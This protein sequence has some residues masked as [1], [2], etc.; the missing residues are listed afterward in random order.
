MRRETLRE[1]LV[2]MA[3]APLVGSVKTRLHG[4]LGAELA[5]EL[6]RCFLRD[7]FALVASVRAVRPGL[8]SVLC[9]APE[10]AAGAFEGLVAPDVVRI[11]QRGEGLGERLVNCFRD[12]LGIGAESVVVIGAD[13]PTLPRAYVAEAF[14]ALAG[15]ADVALGPT[16][17]GGYYLVGA[18]RLHV[19][20]FDGVSWS[21]SRVLE[22]TLERARRA[23][24]DVRLLGEWYD[25]DEPADLDRLR[26]DLTRR[27][28]CDATRA[29]LRAGID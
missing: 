15:A 16:L 9:F 13:S 17:D 28:G 27:G 25:V 8:K 12:V 20:L 18:R 22:E 4:E 26:A 21:T 24:L 1:A 23:S 6:Y 14:D 29:L 5:T 3:K 11:A 7:T 19:R 10:G 2:V